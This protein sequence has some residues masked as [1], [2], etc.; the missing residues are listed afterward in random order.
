MSLK[1]E[2]SDFQSILEVIFKFSPENPNRIISRE[3]TTVEFKAS[4]HRSTNKWDEYGKTI[5]A[6]ANTK[7]GCL[8][9]GVKNRPHD[10][11]GLGNDY[12]D[13][14]DPAQLTIAVLGGM[15]YVQRPV[16]LIQQGSSCTSFDQ[17]PL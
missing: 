14:F 11:I 1:D 9:F 13:E 17:E 4:F 16:T 2:K 10:L 12:F 5:A 8:V 15:R 3:S 6:F 7:G